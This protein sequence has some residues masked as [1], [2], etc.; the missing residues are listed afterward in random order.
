M[1]NVQSLT[2]KLELLTASVS[3]LALSISEISINQKSNEGKTQKQKFN[4][5]LESL[6]LSTEDFAKKMGLYTKMTNKLKKIDAASQRISWLS[7]RNEAKAYHI[8]EAQEKLGQLAQITI[9]FGNIENMDIIKERL[10]RVIEKHGN[11]IPANDMK[12]KNLNFNPMLIAQTGF[13]TI[14]KRSNYD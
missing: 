2:K 1:E 3:E 8:I 7:N 9:A 13:K 6:S 11:L 5:L 14:T 12:E 10:W 4:S